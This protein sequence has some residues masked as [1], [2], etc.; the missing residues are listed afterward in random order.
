[1]TQAKICSKYF[2]K[3][4][5]QII[6]SSKYQFKLSVIIWILLVNNSTFSLANSIAVGLMAITESEFHHSNLVCNSSTFSLENSVAVGLMA[7][8]EALLLTAKI[9]HQDD[10]ITGSCSHGDHHWVRT[11]W[12]QWEFKTQFKIWKLNAG[13]AR[14]SYFK[15]FLLDQ[16]SAAK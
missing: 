10:G 9:I 4:F 11:I 15:H 2:V 12:N 7:I 8:A 5:F 1:M 3:I 6:K 13:E 14:E 16:I